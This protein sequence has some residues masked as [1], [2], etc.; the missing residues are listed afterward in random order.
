MGH[1]SSHYLFSV[2]FIN[3]VKSAN[4]LICRQIAELRTS[5]AEETMMVKKSNETVESL[6]LAAEQAE[7]EI[8]KLQ[9][10]RENLNSGIHEKVGPLGEL[11]QIG[12][13]AAFQIRLENNG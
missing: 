12:T 3:K 1:F 4:R 6:H 11:K 5:F 13:V 8:L 9:G 10:D 7:A 2:L